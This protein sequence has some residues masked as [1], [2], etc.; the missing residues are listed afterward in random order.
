MPNS[1]IICKNCGHRFEGNF[2]SNCGQSSKVNRIDSHY[3]AEEIS[4]GL[5]QV[6]RGFFYTI[7]ELFIRPGV[8]IKNFLQGKRQNYFKPIP[9]VLLASTL[10]VFIVYLLDLNTYSKDFESGFKA[11]V[12]E[13]EMNKASSI[14]NVLNWLANNHAYTLLILLPFYSLSS[15][16]AFIKSKYNYFEHLVLNIYI[17]GQQMIIY[18]VSSF[19]VI[20]G[21]VTEIIPVATGVIFNYWAFHQIFETTFFAKISLFILTY[22]LYTLQIALLMVIGISLFETVGI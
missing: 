3:V 22:V 20:K 4:N 11:G 21:G 9:F 19:F 15:Y 6:N 5:F 2:C 14:L 1:L 18:L 7:K 10:Y 8:T 16:I 17:S 12:H 13:S